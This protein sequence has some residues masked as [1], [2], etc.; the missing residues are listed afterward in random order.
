L[1]V[2]EQRRCDRGETRETDEEQDRSE[3]P[4]RENA[5][6]EEGKIAST[7]CGL[8]ANRRA[9]ACMA[10]DPYER[11]SEPRTEVEQCGQHE[12]A[13]RRQQSLRKRRA[14]AEENRGGKTERGALLLSTTV[15]DLA[16]ALSTMRSS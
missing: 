8:P 11:Q 12:R 2:E 14:R 5:P 13:A 16:H 9:A 15:P 3:N 1:E 6:R 4:S 7:N 10:G